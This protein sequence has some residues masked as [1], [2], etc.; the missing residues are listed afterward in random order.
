MAL[1]AAGAALAPIRAAAQGSPASLLRTV[2]DRGKL[3]V[4]TGATNPPWHFEDENGKLTGMDIALAHML[5]KGLFD[6]ED[7]VEFVQQEPAA[8]VPNIVTGKVDIV[9]QFMTVTPQRA[10]QVAFSR[11]YCVEGGGL[12]VAP[13]GKYKTYKDLLAGGKS[14]RAAI[15]RNV[16]AEDHVHQKLP[17][18][19]VMQL[20]TSANALQAVVADVAHV[21]SSTAKWLAKSNPGS[22]RD[23][24]YTGGFSRVSL[25]CAA[26]RLGDPDWLHWVDTCLNVAMHG[27]DFSVYSAAFEKFFGEKPPVQMAGFPPF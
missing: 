26:V 14:V 22:Y 2:L 12:L 7:K 3:I 21:D 9:L 13:S 19:Q 4:G 8:R 5:A 6:D 17:E 25:Y 24:G 11:P 1:A 15:L 16:Y 27:D 10:Q 23:A 20:D 18:A